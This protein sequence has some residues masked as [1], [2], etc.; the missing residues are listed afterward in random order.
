MI[1]AFATHSLLQR[2]AFVLLLGL[3]GALYA[4]QHWRVRCLRTPAVSCAGPRCTVNRTQLS[5][6]LAHPNRLGSSVRIL[7]VGCS[8]HSGV[9]LYAIRPDSLLARLG[10]RSGD[11]VRSV[12]G[13]EL[14]SPD[15]AIGLYHTLRTAQHVSV[16]LVRGGQTLTMRYTI[17]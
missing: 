17:I 15:K 14:S 8:G 5:D 10:I 12:N 13:I 2:S 11:I 16:E 3:G 4:E 1:A 9:R 7:P 6:L